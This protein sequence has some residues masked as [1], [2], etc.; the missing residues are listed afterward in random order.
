[1]NHWNN[2]ITTTIREKESK[3]EPKKKGCPPLKGRIHRFYKG[4]YFQDI[5]LT[6]REWQCAQALRGGKRA[7]EIAES[8][9]LSKRTVE[10][11]IK[12]T[13]SK[14]GCKKIA[15]LRL[16]LL[17]NFKPKIDLIADPVKKIL[18]QNEAESNFLQ[19]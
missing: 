6:N 18:T 16:L 1:M 15:E 4:E 13:K 10:F 12:K 14:T 5:Y 19:I 8:L 9:G 11:Y 7:R 3:L 17:Q 2:F